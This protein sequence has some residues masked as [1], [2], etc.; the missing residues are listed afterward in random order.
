MTTSR[1]T[2]EQAA[3]ETNVE[4]NFQ[5]DYLR[6]LDDDDRAD[7]AEAR[8]DRVERDRLLRGGA[9]DSRYAA[10][11]ARVLEFATTGR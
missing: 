1:N 4:L 9:Y 2:T 7:E 5:I 8:R 6:E 3:Y 10:D 11:V